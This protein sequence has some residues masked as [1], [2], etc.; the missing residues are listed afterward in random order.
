MPTPPVLCVVSLCYTEAQPR[1][2]FG[3]RLLV[4][5]IALIAM[6]L[7]AAQPFCAAEQRYAADRAAKA[8]AAFLAAVPHGD[9]YATQPGKWVPADPQLWADPMSTEK[10]RFT[11]EETNYFSLW[12]ADESVG[13]IRY[14]YRLGIHPLGTHSPKIAKDSLVL[15]QDEWSGGFRV[16]YY[17]H[18]LPDV[19]E[20]SAL[21]GKDR[22]FNIE[23]ATYDRERDRWFSEIV[24]DA[25]GTMFG[26][27]TRDGTRDDFIFMQYQYGMKR[28]GN[29]EWV[30]GQG[31]MANKPGGQSRIPGVMERLPKPGEPDSDL[32]PDT[33]YLVGW[34]LFGRGPLGLTSIL[35]ACHGKGLP[36]GE[37]PE[38]ILDNPT[39]FDYRADG[40]P[41]AWA[42]SMYMQSGSVNASGQYTM[43]FD[44]VFIPPEAVPSIPK[45]ALT[46]SPKGEPMLLPGD[47]V[48]RFDDAHP[49]LGWQLDPNGWLSPNTDTIN[50]IHGTRD[51]FLTSN[52]PD[53]SVSVLDG[54]TKKWRKLVKLNAK[55]HVALGEPSG[56]ENLFICLGVQF[57]YLGAA[58][59][60]DP[61][62]FVHD[63]YLASAYPIESRGGY[64]VEPAV[65][66]IFREVLGRDPG[67]EEAF[68]ST[69]QLRSGMS[70]RGLRN[71]VVSGDEAKGVLRTACRGIVARAPTAGEVS[72]WQSFLRKGGTYEQFV[73][74]LAGGTG[75]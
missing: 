32:Y 45:A 50:A 44:A 66:R 34:P 30:P 27:A 53:S 5:K 35:R 57:P 26:V 24:L 12:N 2:F 1:Q 14:L 42:V 40:R 69:A 3:G 19:G 25:P 74:R 61:G 17:T 54:A 31:P 64:L 6:T 4:A 60:L 73:T 63:I 71:E 68:R 10:C 39:L 55:P 33:R 58:V 75:A 49:E 7:L 43:K 65:V 16:V 21:Y 23:R 20:G 8:A 22:V 11:A 37:A 56:T 62:V 48:F 28:G 67:P 29:G 72:R 18:S 52:W 51:Q 47:W 46:F 9:F 59:G 15:S 36:G 13:P 70:E 41:R 38:A